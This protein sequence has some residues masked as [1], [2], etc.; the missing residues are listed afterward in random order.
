M[1]KQVLSRDNVNQAWKRVKAN[2]GAAGIDDMTVDE[3]PEYVAKHWTTIK[4][5][6]LQETYR[7]TPVKRK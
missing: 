1:L 5:Q 7:P 6:L 2:K 3:F 4:Q